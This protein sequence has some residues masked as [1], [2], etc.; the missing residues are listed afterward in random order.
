MPICCFCGCCCSLVNKSCPT[1]CYSVNYTPPG[2]SVHCISQA[3]IL[4]WVAI[5]SSRDLPDP[6]IKTVSPALAG[7]FFTTEPP[8][9]SYIY[10][11]FFR[12][13]S[14]EVIYSSSCS[15]V[16]QLGTLHIIV[17]M[18]T[19]APHPGRHQTRKGFLILPVPG[20]WNGPPRDLTMHFPHRS[21]SLES[22][23]AGVDLVVSRCHRE[24]Q[25]NWIVRYQWNPS[26]IYTHGM[27]S[28]EQLR[29]TLSHS[30]SEP[31]CTNSGLCV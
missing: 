23:Q 25:N 2:S 13:F 31:S 17:Y 1:L 7:R 5:S 26:D 8:G 16:C 27:W 30:C 9:K 6:G 18:F 29:C 14:L 24:K 21:F 10:M 3:R 11:F 15:T 19:S 22:E 20:T 4:E 12:V 28:Q